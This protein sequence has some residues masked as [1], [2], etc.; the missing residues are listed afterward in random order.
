[1]LIQAVKYCAMEPLAAAINPL[2]DHWT[3][4]DYA[5][6]LLAEIIRYQKKE[7]IVQTKENVFHYYTCNISCIEQF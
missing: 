6:R 7:L 1:M 5:C 3:L 2:N 4:R